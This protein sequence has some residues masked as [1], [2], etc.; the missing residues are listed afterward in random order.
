MP[1]TLEEFRNFEMPDLSRKSFDVS[2]SHHRTH[3]IEC[4]TAWYY[5]NV[6]LVTDREKLILEGSRIFAVPP[7]V[8]EFVLGI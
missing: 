2:W 1:M 4:A 5:N 6:D 7:H 8:L 3:A